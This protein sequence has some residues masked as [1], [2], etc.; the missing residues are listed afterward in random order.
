MRAFSISWRI[1]AVA[2]MVLLATSA[3]AVTPNPDGV[4]IHERVFNDCPISILSTTNMYPM[5]VAIEDSNTA[6]GGFANL[7]VWRFAEG[8]MDA[9][10]SN[11]SAFRFSATLTLT[12]TG[13]GE[14]GLQIAPW[15]SPLVDG[16]F[17]VRTT[18]GE[19][20]CFGGR[21]PFYSFTASDGVT[22]AKGNAINL[23]MTYYPN[24][25]TM[26]NPATVEYTLIYEGMTYT[27]GALAF[28]EGNPAEDPPYGLWGI[29][30]D[31]E[32]GG[33]MQYLLSAADVP[34]GLRAAWEDICFQSLTPV[35]IEDTT[36]GQVKALFQ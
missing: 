1:A 8:G 24:D 35:R 16:R 6:C 30:N 29:L 19:I 27:S 3:V 14:A 33:H 21:L 18:D 17:N 22:Y 20:A 9:I 15:W 31:A 34:N 2:G 12:G 26:A 13:E 10:F 5:L 32:V 11:D 23:C 28:D 4:V 36:W 25:L 7:H